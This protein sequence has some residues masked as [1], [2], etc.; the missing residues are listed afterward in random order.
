MQPTWLCFWLIPTCFNFCVD[1]KM[2]GTANNFLAIRDSG[3]F[4]FFSS[5]CGLIMYAKLIWNYGIMSL[6]QLRKFIFHLLDLFDKYDSYNWTCEF[7][8]E[9]KA[10]NKLL[11]NYKKLIILTLE[12]L[13]N[14]KVPKNCIIWILNS[15]LN[16]TITHKPLNLK[17]KAIQHISSF[18]THMFN[19]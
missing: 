6:Y 12:T 13:R 18:E 5:K 17:K 4:K 7:Q 19:L 9:L 15:N 16:N 3:G 11:R 10:R 1:L 14:L 8:D 2:K